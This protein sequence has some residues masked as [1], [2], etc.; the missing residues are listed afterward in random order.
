[1]SHLDEADVVAHVS[2]PKGKLLYAIGDVHGRHDLLLALI[3]RIRADIAAGPPPERPPVVLFL[4]DYVDRGGASQ[5][6]IQE[7]MTLQQDPDLRVVALRGNHDQYVLDFLDDATIGPQWLDYG[8]GVTLASY[9]VIPP[10]NRT[11]AAAW[12]EARRQLIERMP[13]QHLDFL[14]ATI[15]VATFG[16]YVFVHAGV[17]PDIPLSEQD[18]AD[19]MSIRKPF[20]KAKEPLPGKVVVFGHTPFDRPS[21]RGG[22]LPLDTGAYAT[23]VLTAARIFEDR[24]KFIQTT[25]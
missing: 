8:G 10:G 9:G 1:V 24:I 16:D 21:L 5:K 6:V 4:G 2:G 12:R 14:N 7:I 18:P 15:L 3:Q 23:G 11:D 17:R 22:K 20:L 25:A 13:P 19:Y